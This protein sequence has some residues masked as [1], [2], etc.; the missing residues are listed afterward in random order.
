MWTTPRQITTG[1]PP[2][3]E[4]G[5][6]ARFTP[7]H[8]SGKT[9]VSLTI[10]SV[11]GK[12]QIFKLIDLAHEIPGVKVARKTWYK[13]LEDASTK[14]AVAD[15]T[16]NSNTDITFR[17]SQTTLSDSSKNLEEPSPTENEEEIDDQTR[18]MDSHEIQREMEYWNDLRADTDTLIFPEMIVMEQHNLTHFPSQPWCK[19]S[20]SQLAIRPMTKIQRRCQ[21]CGSRQSILVDAQSRGR[22]GNESASRNS[23]DNVG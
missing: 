19:D 20:K 23:L 3:E 2:T 21:R 18:S 14:E 5:P 13:L 7:S 9:N 16:A 22:C 8:K 4:S 6:L 11:A 1:T 15:D 10:A 12:Q 17:V